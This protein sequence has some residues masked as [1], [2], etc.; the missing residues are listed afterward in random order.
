[1]T[2]I[3]PIILA[4]LDLCAAIVYGFNGDWVRVAYWVLAAGLTLTTLW[5]K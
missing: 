2:S 5:M 4:I 1:M 3:F